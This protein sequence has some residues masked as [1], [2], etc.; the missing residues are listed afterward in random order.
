MVKRIHFGHRHR[1][2]SAQK[3]LAFF[4]CI[5]RPKQR[6]RW[7]L[8]KEFKLFPRKRKKTRN[9]QNCSH[10]NSNRRTATNARLHQLIGLEQRPSWNLSY[11]MSMFAHWLQSNSSLFCTNRDRLSR[12][13]FNFF[14]STQ[15]NS[16]RSEFHWNQFSWSVKK[17]VCTTS[18]ILNA[19]HWR[20]HDET[21]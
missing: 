9:Q 14:N 11:D 5:A 21:R 1:Q 7:L 17:C 13:F 12:C 19:K 6:W 16:V 2:S 18:K 3:T 10:R 8:K 20:F 4:C 15:H